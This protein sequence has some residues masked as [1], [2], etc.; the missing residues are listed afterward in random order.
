[1]TKTIRA[2]CAHDCPDMCSLLVEVDGDRILKIQGDPEEPFTDGFACAKV[3]RDHEVVH[4]PMRVKTPL[5]RTGPKGSGR[6]EPITWDAALDEIE[7]RWKAIIKQ[8]GPE[9]LLGYCYSSHQGQINRHL[10]NGFFHALGTS[11]LIAGTVCDSCVDVAWDLTL[12]GVGCADPDTIDESELIVIWGCDVKSVNVHLWQKIERRQRAGVKVVM[13]D[14]HRNR[15]A[16]GAD[17]HLPINV[18]TDAALAIGIVHVLV[19]D[20]K[21]DEAYLAKHTLGWEQWKREVIAKFPP[22]RVAEITG[23]PVADIERL[24]A[25]YGATKKSFLRI[26][27]GMTRVL[28]GGQAMRAV[29]VL[30]AVTGAYGVRGGG[31]MSV[32]AGSMGFNFAPVRKPSGPAQARQVNHSRLGEA[33]L[34]LKDPPIQAL[35]IASNNP[36]VTNPDIQAVRKGL[37]R[38][39]LFTVVH[40]PVMTD[41]ARY[42]D[43]VLPATT[44]L[45]TSDFFRGYGTYYMQFSPVAVAPQGE[46]WSNVRLAQELARRMG[47]T[48]EVFR[49]PPEKIFPKFF[50]GAT[51]VVARID[52]KRLLDH[53]AIKV[54]PEGVG[55]AFGTPSGKLEIYSEALARQGLPPMPVGEPD[56]RELEDA[57]RWPLRLL[58][59][60]GYF[61]A[62]TAY[63][64]SE[65][66]R[67]REGEPLCVLHP[68]DAAKRGLHAG[69]KVRL[70][71]DRGEAGLVLKVSDEIREGVALVPG[72]RPEAET[73]HGGINNL[74]SDALTD[75]G[76]QATYQSTF[77]DV[78]KW[79]GPARVAAAE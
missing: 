53:R 65:F 61:Q 77:L 30:P 10:P 59:T 57:K 69:D 9:A 78:E 62:H 4:S 49:L 21:T 34:T 46:A 18:G 63:V 52:P 16:Q 66:L 47:L 17:W 38:E 11:R 79:S 68:N 73:V 75:I 3:N 76:A 28:R 55:Q 15:T 25:M 58:T 56:P 29:A 33:L 54:A 32:T 24:A 19:R 64:G 7:T 71:N 60:P 23:L 67:K 14:P 26:G 51:G 13:I 37:S 44:Y 48:D 42:A 31:A 72:Q 1:M 40:D 50:E 27:W 35:F 43:I 8:H 41:T 74:C 70:F 45:E 6:F 2:T 22:A 36:A 5:R 39:D 20:G 12:G